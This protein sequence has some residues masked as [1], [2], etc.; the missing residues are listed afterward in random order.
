MRDFR[1]LALLVH[2]SLRQNGKSKT[3]SA[4]KFTTI[5]QWIHNLQGNTVDD[6]LQM[7]SNRLYT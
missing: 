7:E 5:T 3:P 2:F 1:C 4:Y 6:E